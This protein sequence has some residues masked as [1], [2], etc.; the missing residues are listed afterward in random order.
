MTPGV[1]AT[2]FTVPDNLPLISQG[3]VGTA[4]IWTNTMYKIQDMITQ[5]SPT[6]FAASIADIHASL[7]GAQQAQ[8]A[9]LAS[10]TAA[11]TSE[12]HAKTSETNAKTSETNAAASAAAALASQNA[13]KTSE[14][15]GGNSA[16]AAL[17]SQNAAKTSETNSKTSETNAAASA[18]SSSTRANDSNTS[19]VAAAA[20]AA[21]V[22]AM[23]HSMNAV[24]LGDKTADP[25]VDNNG[26]ALVNGTRYFNTAMNPMRTRVYNNGAW[27]DENLDAEQATASAQQSA[28]AASG[29]ATAAS[30]SQAAAATSE[31]NAKTS[32]TNSAASAAASLASQNAAK[33]SE[34]NAAASASQALGAVS[35]V[36]GMLELDVSA[37]DVTLT[38]AQAG[39]GLFRFTGTW[40][41]A[42]TITFPNTPHPFVA[43]NL[44][45]GGGTGTLVIAATGKAPN[46]SLLAGKPASLFCD[47]T[48]IYATTS[49]PGLGY[50]NVA[51]AAVDTTLSL[52]NV[53]GL[54]IQT[55]AGKKATLPPAATIPQ[56]LG[57]TVQLAAAGIL[58]LSGTDTIT[59]ITAPYTGAVGDTFFCISDGTSNWKLQTYSNKA[60]PTFDTS[61]AAPKVLANTTDNNTDTIQAG[62]SISAKAAGG[63]VR[64][65]GAGASVPAKLTALALGLAL[66][67]ADASAITFSPNATE[68]A[69]FTAAGRLLIGTTTDDAASIIQAKG[70]VRSITGGFQ[71]PDGTVQTTANGVTAPVSTPVTPV[72]GATVIPT[73]GYNQGFVQLFKNNGRMIPGVDFTTPDGVN[74][75]LTVA[76]TG[77]DRYEYLTSVIYSPS[78]A[79]QPTSYSTTLAVGASTITTPYNVGC[80][81]VFKNN[82]KLIPTRDY[83]G[84]D[85]ATIALVNASDNATDVY[86]V[87]TFTPFAVNGMLPL[88]G[89]TMTG[90]IKRSG[91]AGTNRSIFWQ[92]AGS[93]RWELGA[94][95]VAEAGSNAGSDLFVNR[96]ND[97]GTYVDTPLTINRSTGLITLGTLS[98]AGV[99]TINGAATFNST[100]TMTGK[101]TITA[102]GMSV[103]G[104][105]GFSARPLFGAATP[106]DTANLPNPQ[107]ALGYT[108]INKAGDSGIGSLS[109]SAVTSANYNVG[110][111]GV[112]LMY[113][114]G[115]TGAIGFRTGGTPKFFSMDAGGNGNALNGSWVNG[116]D[117]RLKTNIE[118]IDDALA[119]VCA[120]RGVYY[121]KKDDPGVRHVGVIAQETQDVFPEVVYHVPVAAP[122]P[123]P[124]S[125]EVHQPLEHDD[126]LGVSYGNLAGPLIEAIKILAAQNKAL[127]QRVEAL[128]AQQAKA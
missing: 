88:T 114:T 81:W 35:A 91:G 65:E 54:F 10:Q 98:V 103:T 109:I 8:A 42:R 56:G 45:T 49:S 72:A 113:D 99:A 127:T 15:N 78:V 2:D 46:V 24:W 80:F 83:T 17:A 7:N 39:N 122:I 107:T 97:A 20:S 121:E 43:E 34:T 100:T 93:S 51:S 29:S 52:S 92:T 104:T 69:R 96:Y 37:Q 26:D 41:G 82:G 87:V 85:G 118:T 9:A 44:R 40:T 16:A 50:S 79:F 21:Q 4:A 38:T 28:A 120:M 30:N 61:V 1:V 12:Q 95:N 63:T 3:D 128:E 126:Y 36:N 94:S 27:Q 84:T 58:A 32:E 76:A 67:T 112:L 47:G 68:A 110:S 19:A 5:I 6:G 22:Q 18:A 33:T 13:A 25:T 75:N 62:G 117:V 124:D 11:T 55:G 108:P 53:G 31:G 71:F 14:T 23:L 64:L 115:G 119:K 101:L 111:G 86:E 102:G 105:V 48:G 77:R 70:I 89:G 66:V 116:S 125:G 123:D 90:D 57:V 106:W 59:G 74:I 60:S 73:N